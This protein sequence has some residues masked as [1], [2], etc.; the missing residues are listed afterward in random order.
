MFKGVRTSFKKE[1]LL[2]MVNEIDNTTCSK[3]FFLLPFGHCVELFFVFCT[4]ISLTAVGV[5]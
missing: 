5:G 1:R 4:V 2:P 3:Y